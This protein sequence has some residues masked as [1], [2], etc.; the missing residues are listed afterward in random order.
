MYSSHLQLLSRLPIV[1]SHPQVGIYFC[2]RAAEFRYQDRQA[3]KMAHYKQALRG[4][5]DGRCINQFEITAICFSLATI[6][7]ILNVWCHMFTI[8]TINYIS[9]EESGKTGKARLVWY[10]LMPKVSRNRL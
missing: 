6:S 3:R 7:V 1:G 8:L 2:A 4:A 5:K 10:V 9:C